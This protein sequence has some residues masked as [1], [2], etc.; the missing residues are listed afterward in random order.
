M[1]PFAMFNPMMMGNP[2]GMMPPMNVFMQ[3]PV[4]EEEEDT[5]K[6]I[7][8]KVLM[9]SRESNASLKEMNF[10]QSKIA[11]IGAA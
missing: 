3:M 11:P 7:L 9:E 4:G 6:N 10:G 2:F 8:K 5:E 1:N